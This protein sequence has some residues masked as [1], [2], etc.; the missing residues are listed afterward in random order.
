MSPERAQWTAKE[1]KNYAAL[2]GL[3]LFRIVTQGLCPGLCYPVPS[4]LQ[5]MFRDKTGNNPEAFGIGIGI[6]IGIGF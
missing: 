4:G 2:T 5:S 3:I 1:Q 6:A